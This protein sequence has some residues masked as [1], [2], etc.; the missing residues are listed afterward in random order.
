MTAAAEF[1]GDTA[2]DQ[3]H[4]EIVSVDHRSDISGTA[5]DVWQTMEH[6]WVDKILPIICCHS[7]RGEEELWTTA[8]SQKARV[9]VDTSGG[10]HDGVPHDNV[11]HWPAAV[12]RLANVAEDIE[13]ESFDDEGRA[14]FLA[15][16]CTTD[17][18]EDEVFAV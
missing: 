1:Q 9:G 18:E 4:D 12:P 8:F 16:T 17:G 15:D 3:I 11:G 7:C 5:T 6:A 14:S 13:K 10:W 2:D